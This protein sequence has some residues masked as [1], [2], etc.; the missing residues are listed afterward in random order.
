[1][2]REQQKQLLLLL[3]ALRRSGGLPALFGDESPEIMLR[4]RRVAIIENV[5]KSELEAVML[6]N[7]AKEGRYV[8]ERYLVRGQRLLLN[9]QPPAAA[10]Q[11]QL[12][13]SEKEE[14]GRRWV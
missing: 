6:G 13:W 10:W 7:H 9:H 11:Q 4:V 3:V 1:M 14:K 2:L 12:V 5:M 8:Y